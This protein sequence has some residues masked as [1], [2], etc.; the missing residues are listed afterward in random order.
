MPANLTPQFRKAEEVYRLASTAPEKIA[1]LEEMLRLVPKHKGTEHVQGDIKSR[2]AKLRKAGEQRKGKGGPDP[3]HVEKH[4]AGQFAVVGA[5]N[6]GKSALVA[7]V[8]EARVNVAAYPF[9]T[10]APAPGMMAF[11]DIQIQLVDLPPVTS[12]GMPTGMMGTL[13]NADGI[14]VCLDLSADDLLEQADICFG[15]MAARGLVPLGAELPEGGEAKPMLLLGTKAD[16]DHAM[17]NLEVLRELRPD[18]GDLLATSA[19]QGAGL[20]ELAQRC[21][22][23]LDIVRV[24]S[25]Q[26]GEPADIDDPFTL[27][28]GSTVVDLA[29]A[30]HGDFAGSLRY[31]RIWGSG[32]FDGQ[33]VQRDHILADK[34]IVELHV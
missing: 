27:S 7:A 30:V 21:F 32:K 25:K 23:M 8:S 22:E 11:K 15:L 14:L 12:D 19:E 26:P 31:A 28:R 13:R 33:T 1:A 6:V 24:Y 5:P 20:A 3:F 10:H 17:E 9:A 29:R 18:L 4:G 2:L 16:A 34:D